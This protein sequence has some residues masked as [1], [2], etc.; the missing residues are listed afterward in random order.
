[1]RCSRFAEH[2]S[3]DTTVDYID[4]QI[5]EVGKDD[6]FQQILSNAYRITSDECFFQP[7]AERP[8][9]SNDFTMDD[10]LDVLGFG[11]WFWS[12]PRWSPS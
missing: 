2:Q 4:D 7:S 9:T 5:A 1:M 3:F 6:V 8:L 11:L 10:S 12:V